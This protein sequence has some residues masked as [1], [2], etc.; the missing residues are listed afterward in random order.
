MPKEEKIPLRKNTYTP[1]EKIMPLVK[2]TEV[3]HNNTLTTQQDY[4]LREVFVNPEH[5]VMIREEARMRNISEQGLLPAGL[6]PEHQ[7]TKLTI[8]RGHTGTE[9]IVVGAP[10]VI[11]SNLSRQKK[12]IKG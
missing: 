12:L 7:F 9:I 4:T 2:F 1:W 8:N 11:E 6:D 3:C 5:V 10:N